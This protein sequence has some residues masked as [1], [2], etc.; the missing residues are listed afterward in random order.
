MIKSP[1]KNCEI[2]ET[3]FPVCSEGCVLLKKVQQLSN[4]D[5]LSSVKNQ[6]TYVPS[7]G[8]SFNNKTRNHKAMS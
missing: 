8:H 7:E 4:N 3:D 6:T 5:A 1:C 2:Y